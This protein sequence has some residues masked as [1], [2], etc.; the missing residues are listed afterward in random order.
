[1][2]RAIS[3]ENL[4]YYPLE[5]KHHTAILSLVAPATPAYKV[6]NLSTIANF[7]A[8]AS[9]CTFTPLLLFLTCLMEV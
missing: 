1:M 2:A 3:K 5:D 9:L 7:P 8:L 4:G 6:L